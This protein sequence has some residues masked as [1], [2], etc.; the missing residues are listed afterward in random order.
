[1]ETPFWI[2]AITCVAGC[3]LYLIASKAKT[4]DPHIAEVGRAAMWVGG[5]VLLLLVCGVR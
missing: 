4:P 3:L 5:L 2:A 1:M